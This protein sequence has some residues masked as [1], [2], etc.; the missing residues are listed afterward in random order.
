MNTPSFILSTVKGIQTVSNSVSMYDAGDTKP[1]LCDDLE[2]RGG[3]EEEGEL[4]REG[5]L[6]A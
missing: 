3:R 2:G 5:T 4:K 6:F 1:A